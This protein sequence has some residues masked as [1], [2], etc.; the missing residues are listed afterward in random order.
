M[1][2]LWVIPIARLSQHLIGVGLNIAYANMA[3]INLP[4]TDQTNFISFHI[5][6]TN[7]AGFLGMMTGTGFVAAFPDLVIRIFGFSFTNM[8]ILMWAEGIGAI[9]VPLMVLKLLPRLTKPE[10]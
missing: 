1:N 10:E 7:I 9:L 8:Q 5:L 3:Y 2:Y 6:V 4:E